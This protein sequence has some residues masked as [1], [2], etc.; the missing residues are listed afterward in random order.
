MYHYWY[1]IFSPDGDLKFTHGRVSMNANDYVREW[2]SGDEVGG[3]FALKYFTM[4][5]RLLSYF[6]VRYFV[7]DLLGDMFGVTKINIGAG[8]TVGYQF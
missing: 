8:I 3:D 4:A 5:I 7:D 1:D 6:N 2:Y